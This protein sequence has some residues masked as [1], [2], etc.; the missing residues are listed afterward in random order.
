MLNA[1]YSKGF[2]KKSEPKVAKLLEM[3]LFEDP[4]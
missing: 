1:I 4:K 3:V 2:Q